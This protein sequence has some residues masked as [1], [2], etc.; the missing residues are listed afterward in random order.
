MPGPAEQPATARRD[1]A[2]EQILMEAIALLDEGG[3]E[4]VKARTLA[5]RVGVAVGSIYYAWGDLDGLIRAANAYT[6]DRL[7]EAC[8]GRLADARKAADGELPALD[9]MMILADGYAEFVTKHYKRW[10]GVL[11]YNRLKEKDAPNWYL[12]KQFALIAVVESVIA[13]LPGAKEPE[14]RR[15]ASQALWASVHGIVTLTLNRR[16]DWIAPDALRG[17]VELVVQAVA[18]KLSRPAD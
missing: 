8:E 16:S 13:R 10:S 7:R 17:H 3:L 12:E 1:A 2:R 9:E 18:E 5:E 15:R 14:A 11:A 4:A 6:Y